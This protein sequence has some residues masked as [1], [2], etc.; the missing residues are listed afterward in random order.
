MKKFL[1][2]GF[3]FSFYVCTL[4]FFFVLSLFSL[5][6]LGALH[7]L[8]GVKLDEDKI[9][10]SAQQVEIL[11]ANSQNIMPDNSLKKN[12][13]LDEVPQHVV[14]SFVSIEDKDFYKHKGLNY[15][16]MLKATLNNIKSFS[17]KEGAS[18][19]SQQLIKNTHL[20]TDKT[21]RRKFDEMVL[22]KELE[23]NYSKDEIM[24]S[25]LNA[26]YFGNG[27][28]GI[29]SA[30]QKY[31]S[32]DAKDLTLAEGALLAGTIKSPKRYS[33]LYNPKNA[34]ERRNLVLKEMY[35][36]QKITK[37]EYEQ[38]INEEIDLRPN[39]TFAS[40]NDYAIC[41]L[42]EACKILK[43]SEKDIN[44][45]GYKIYTYQ[46]KNIQKN[47]EEKAKFLSSSASNNDTLVMSVD[48]KSGGI[49][50]FAGVS[51]S[52]LLSLY[53][54]PG[55]SFKPIISYAPALEKNVISPMSLIL[56]EKTNFDG[57]TPKNYN[58]K[59]HGYVSAK[60]ALACSYNVPS[61][62]I[63]SFTGIPYCKE[64]AQN[65]GISLE[66]EDNGLSLALGGLT[67]GV[68][69]LDLAGAYQTFGNMGEKI[70]L[71]FVKEIKDKNGTTIYKNSEKARCC[72]K[73]STAY[74]VSNMLKESVNSGTCRKLKLD[75]YNIAA[76]SGTAGAKNSDK[77]LDAWNIS[78]TP[79]STLLV[80]CG[81]KEGTLLERNITGGAILANVAQEMY[82]SSFEK[83]EDFELPSDVKSVDISLVDYLENGTIT[84]ASPQTPD[85]Y[86][87]TALFQIDNI[88]KQ[89]STSVF[90]PQNFE[91]DCEKIDDGIKV[92]F[93]AKSY[94]KYS[95]F[96]TCDNEQKLLTTFEDK[97]GLVEFIDK[98]VKSGNIYSYYV[99]STNV[100]GDEKNAKSNIVKMLLT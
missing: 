34:L 58:D 99:L 38:A 3:K 64:F 9:L 73:K 10:Y 29:E 13:T 48:N 11:D 21:F 78:Y 63:L 6:N 18:T 80:W 36:D 87:T 95:L 55:S 90:E 24:A 40:E 86:K 94:L 25:Y 49:T 71:H 88:P 12:I 52:S 65:M 2:R 32:K 22:A 42:R 5:L 92:F 74:L 37:Q 83:T 1:K 23:K 41:A 76:K 35:K 79:K 15:K 43:I 7:T 56:D 75:G 77:N 68:K 46:N 89:V 69:F 26:I 97:K 39:T 28:I 31:F 53:R 100:F 82:K 50:S 27:A 30:S 20:S 19:I 45:L 4:L 57:Y 59:Y 93:D 91:I 84:L 72:M 17:L 60:E 81:A 96:R 98:D 14:D 67:R 16:R 51:G 33:P 66:K 8:S 47:A 44:L 54:Q 70:D 61:V 85:R 62:K